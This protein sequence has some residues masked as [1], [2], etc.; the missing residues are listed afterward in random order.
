[1]I[2]W[3]DNDETAPP[4]SREAEQ[5]G[6]SCVPV[7]RHD[8]SRS[9]QPHPNGVGGLGGDDRGHEDSGHGEDTSAHGITPPHRVGAP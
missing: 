5:G 6:G 9:G 2:V 8:Q 1:M 7:E 4:P 3:E